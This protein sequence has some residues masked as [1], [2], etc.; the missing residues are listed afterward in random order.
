[1]WTLLA[2]DKTDLPFGIRLASSNFHT[3][4]LRSGD[5]VSVRSGFGGIGPDLVVDCRAAPRWVPAC[6]EKLD[7]GL[8]SRLAVMAMAACD[9]AWCE[10]AP[11]ARAVRAA[12][13]DTT[14]LG[15]VLA[16]VVGRGPGATPSGDDVLVG[17]L[18]VLTSPRAGTAGAR[19]A[20]SL[21]R[22]LR[23]LL[24][25][26]TD[27]S[28]HLLHQATKGLFGRDLHELV[29]ALIGASTP[30]QLSEKIR[31]VAETGATSGADACE[32]LLAFAPSY[33]ASGNERASA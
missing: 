12:L 13:I 22:A 4:G 19:A 26:T 24:P 25:T 5:L 2:E 31:R 17:V 23:P 16:R 15:D 1:M 3:L 27:L 14:A 29:N 18:A 11:M 32:G 21:G 10:S 28:G 30:R 7:P 8:E 20:E 33:F 9:R 6:E